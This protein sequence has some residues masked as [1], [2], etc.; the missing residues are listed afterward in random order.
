M[1]DLKEFRKANNLQQDEVAIFLAVSKSFISQ[2][3]N[4][5]RELPEAQLSKLML[6]RNGW[7]TSALSKEAKNPEG[8]VVRQ[9]KIPLYDDTQTI[10]GL[11]GVVANVDDQAR[12]SEWIDAG[13]WFPAATSAIYHYGDSMV[14]YPSGSVLVLKRVNDPRLLING[15]HYVIETSEFRVTKRILVKEDK[16]VA[17]STNMETYPGGEL[18]YAPFEIPKEEIRHID[19]VLGCVMKRFS[20][21][22]IRIK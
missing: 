10:G 6:N 5:K 21:G 18:I 13:D 22:P 12:V 19:L 15:E 7:D 3:E 11:N 4:G 17:Y 1:V 2:V 14:E 9:K 16:I 20:N 8:N